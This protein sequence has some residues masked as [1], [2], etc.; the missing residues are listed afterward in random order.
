MKIKVLFPLNFV[1]CITGKRITRKTIVHVVEG[2][3]NLQL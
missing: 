2:V 3:I 1:I